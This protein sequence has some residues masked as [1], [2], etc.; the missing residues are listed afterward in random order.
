MMG[1]K[2]SVFQIG[3]VTI[4]NQLQVCNAQASLMVYEWDGKQRVDMRN[5]GKCEFETKEVEREILW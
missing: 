1:L 2:E 4:L 5:G 3:S